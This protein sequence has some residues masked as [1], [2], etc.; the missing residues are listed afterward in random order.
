MPSGCGPECRCSASI[1]WRFLQDRR[2][3]PIEDIRDEV[4]T[5]LG[6]ES[7]FSEVMPAKLAARLVPAELV[8]CSLWEGLRE[9]LDS[10]KIAMSKRWV[11]P[12]GS[13]AEGGTIPGRVMEGVEV[14]DDFRLDL[15]LRSLSTGGDATDSTS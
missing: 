15:V 11:P 12:Y 10:G 9:L 7:S 13:A 2:W 14:I 6:A 4:A 1:I 8:A 3:V 5:V